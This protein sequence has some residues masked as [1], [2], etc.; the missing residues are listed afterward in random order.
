MDLTHLGA[1]RDGTDLSA[2]V[3][4]RCAGLVLPD[5]TNAPYYFQRYLE[6]DPEV[7]ERRAKYLAVPGA[8]QRAE[9]TYPALHAV[10]RVAYVYVGW[11][12]VWRWRHVASRQGRLRLADIQGMDPAWQRQMIVAGM[13][14]WVLA[15]PEWVPPWPLPPVLPGT[16]ILGQVYRDAAPVW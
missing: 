15:R 14:Q 10:P 7:T 5:T 9:L 11:K 8:T 1:D 12:G 6:A 13:Y 4:D 16:A 2:L 3:P